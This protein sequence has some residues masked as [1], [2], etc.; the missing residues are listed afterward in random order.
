MFFTGKCFF[1][2]EKNLFSDFF[3]SKELQ[4]N[5]CIIYILSLFVLCVLLILPIN[6]YATARNIVLYIL[7]IYKHLENW[8][9]NEKMCILEGIL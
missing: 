2:S 5:L 1:F 6:T 7:I 9:G 3:F 4:N 8:L